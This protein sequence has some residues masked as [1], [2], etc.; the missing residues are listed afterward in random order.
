MEP[1][2]LLPK[3]LIIPAVGVAAVSFGVVA[4]IGRDVANERTAGPLDRAAFRVADWVFSALPGV[5]EPLSNASRPPAMITVIVVMAIIALWRR[6]YRVASLCVLG[7]VV[8][9]G[10][11]SWVLKPVV[12]RTHD[13]YL[14]Y[15]SG[16]TTTLVSILVVLTLVVVANAPAGERLKQTVVCGAVTVVLTAV[17]VSAIV[18]LRYHYLT[19]SVGS[20]FW[21]TGGVIT[22]AALLDLLPGTHPARRLTREQ[23]YRA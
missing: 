21:A 20:F 7:P 11:N 8:T 9:A 22:V 10:V 16:H 6:R 18:G 13:G 14:A 4:A 17:A 2:R 3:A 5:A 19:D 23:A 15:P 1:N 12:G